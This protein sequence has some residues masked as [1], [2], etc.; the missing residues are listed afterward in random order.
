MKLEVEDFDYQQAIDKVDKLLANIS[1]ACIA[2][3]DGG[4]NLKDMPSAAE[5]VDLVID[6]II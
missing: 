6:T 2:C 4:D 5:I 3:S 1:C